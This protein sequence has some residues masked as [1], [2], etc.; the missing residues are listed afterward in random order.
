M[1]EAL[2]ALAVLSGG[3]LALW[4]RSRWLAARQRNVATQ[5]ATIVVEGR[6]WPSRVE[7]VAG[8]PAV[9]RFDRREDD[10]C[11]E[12]LICELL[13]SQHRLTA[14]AVTAV[15]FIP[16][17]PGRYAFTC[18]MGIYAGELV[19]RAASRGNG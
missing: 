13:P 3:T 1:T 5:Q 14:H 7:L 19:V 16:T 11:S 6:Y 2:I 8:I 9:L 10:P 15:R 12:L 18:G 17:R 4:G